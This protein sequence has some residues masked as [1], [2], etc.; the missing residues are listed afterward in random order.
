MNKLE[1]AFQ[2]FDSYNQEDPVTIVWEGKDY[3][4]NYFYALQLYQWV[5][6]LSPGAG[7]AL[8]LASRC[9]HIGRW[10][11]PRTQYPEGKAGYLR[12]RT[13][14]SRFHASIAGDIL[15]K[16]GYDDQAILAVQRI[17]RKENIKTDNDMQIMEDALCL[18]FL[19]FQFD[20]FVEKHEEGKVI[21]VLQKSW[22]KMDQQGRDAAMTLSYHEKSRGIIDK[23]LAIS[24]KI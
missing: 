3:P 16:A 6:K 19:Q 12:W 1:R 15:K 4:E 2:L 21:R 5:K 24:N 20:D 13:E 7:E 10:Q 17:N 11:I 23:A 14:L 18:V 9:Q 8:L 22:H